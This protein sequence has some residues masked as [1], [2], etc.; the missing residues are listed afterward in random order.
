V[1]TVSHRPPGLRPDNQIA[2]L[3]IAH[4]AVILIEDR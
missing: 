4:E 1:L 2:L 3:K